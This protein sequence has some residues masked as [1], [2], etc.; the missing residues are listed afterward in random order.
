[1]SYIPLNINQLLFKAHYVLTDLRMSLGTKSI[2]FLFTDSTDH[3]YCGFKCTLFAVEN[4]F[5]LANLEFLY[6]LV[7]LKCFFVFKKFI[8]FIRHLHFK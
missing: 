3:F 1:M 6:Y 7:E 4:K 8:L 5:I 2:Y